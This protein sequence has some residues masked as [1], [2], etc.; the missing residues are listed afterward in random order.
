[1]DRNLLGRATEGTDAPTPGYLYVDLAKQATANPTACAEMAQYLT[2]KLQNKQNPNIKGKCCKVIAKLCDQ[3]P[4]N[5]FRRCI[6]Q[7]ASAV[8]AIKEA[9]N[10]RGP[11]DPLQ[12]DAKN[13]KVRAAAREALDAVYNEAASSEQASAMPMQGMS[14]SYGSAPHHAGGAGGGGG[15]GG[16]PAPSSS[17]GGPRK[18]Q[19]IGN[20][21]YSDPRNDP[22]YNGSAPTNFVDAVKE[23]GD[24]VKGMIQDP[25]ARNVG[26]PQMDVP[27]RGH[28]GNL[29]GYG[30]NRGSYGGGAPPGS[31]ELRAQTNGEWTMA[32]N[33]GPQA[34][35][36]GASNEYYKERDTSF[37]NMYNSS[38]GGQTS[39]SAGRVGGSWGTATAAPVGAPA[40]PNYGTPSVTVHH[41]PAVTVTAGATSDGTYEKNLIMEMCPPGGVKPVPPPD[42]LANFARSV[43]SLNPDL[44]CP[45]LLDLLE[46]G[47]PWIIRA[48][49]LCVM[50]SAIQNGV[51]KDG[52]NPYKTFFFAC[53]GEI[54]PLA[55]HPRSAIKDPAKRVLLKL[56]VTPGPG[57]DAPV[58]AP[59]VAALPAAAAPNLLDFDDAP[60][61]PPVAPPAAP[62]SQPPP[63]PPAVAP[64]AAPPAN[65]MFGGMTVKGTGSFDGGA[66]APAPPAAA[67]P[68]AAA[69]APSLLDFAPAPVPAAAADPFSA[70]AV[71]PARPAP[72]AAVPATTSMFGELSVKDTAAAAPAPP[73]ETLADAT[74]AAGGS[75][76][77]FIN[78]S[79]PAPATAAETATP[80]PTPPA[81]QSTFDPLQG[82][83]AP[84]PSMP[85]MPTGGMNPQVAAVGGQ[86]ML[87]LSPEQ[88]QAMAYQQ[89]MMQQ[90]MQQMQMAM[91]MQQQGGRPGVVPPPAM[92]FRTSSGG[93]ANMSFRGS[94]TAPRPAQRDD[95]K[96]DF[97]KDTM[98][99][100]MKK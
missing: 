2:R 99:A 44:I 67:P 25:L 33:R 51:A 11:M 59:P 90:Q 92:Q 66:A 13:E 81:S 97:V 74:P 42:K 91:A 63:P 19:G 40:N 50:E 5:Q 72:V 79:A 87:A 45:V 73:T 83:A 9:I 84:A 38:G 27:N 58:A 20:P 49:A 10:F 6:A 68:V 88:M 77:G 24:I 32:S 89:M 57:A 21:A 70:P 12:G 17:S 26:K 53:A 62:P 22:R 47:Q 4:R 94:A 34:V 75:A 35:T 23:A 37:N 65:N 100:T 98:S 28:S 61:P 36:G 80:T 18:M 16:A 93:S 14:A 56:G 78:N 48:K 95:K 69:P 39:V 30:N 55:L 52:T 85:T 29:P 46:E 54:Q 15:Y 60:A 96:F 31:A 7:D 43:G 82:G 1:M 86:P 3:V 64:P 76:F 41:N 71:S 8:A